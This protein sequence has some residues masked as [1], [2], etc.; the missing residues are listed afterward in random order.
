MF[1]A[2]ACSS[3]FGG[4]V[5]PEATERGRVNTPTS[6]RLHAPHPLTPAPQGGGG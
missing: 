5:S 3:P 6:G 4:E 2:R 1:K